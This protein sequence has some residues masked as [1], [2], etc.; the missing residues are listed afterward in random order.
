MG[1]RVATWVSTVDEAAVRNTRDVDVMIHRTD[2]DKV[3]IAL[4]AKGLVYRHVAGIDVFLDSEASTAR[5]AVHI[6]YAGEF[7]REGEPMPIPA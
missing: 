5:D 6:L 1:T 4:E 3:R 7:V 2:L